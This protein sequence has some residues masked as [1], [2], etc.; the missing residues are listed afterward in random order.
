MF[1]ESFNT[2]MLD[3]KRPLMWQ[4]T[5]KFTFKFGRRW[6]VGWIVSWN[7]V[8]IFGHS[9]SVMRKWNNFHLKIIAIINI[10]LVTRLNSPSNDY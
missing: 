9:I 6:N 3:E 1:V 10:K 2:A 4:S 5:N 8:T 7:C